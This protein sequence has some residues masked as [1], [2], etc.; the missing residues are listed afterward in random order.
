MGPYEMVITYSK[1][2][3]TL[4]RTRFGATGDG[5]IQQLRSIPDK[6]PEP[7]HSSILQLGRIRNKLVHED[8]FEL[9]DVEGYQQQ[10]ERVIQQLK[11]L[12]VHG[13]GRTVFTSQSTKTTHSRGHPAG[14]DED[15]LG[16]EAVAFTLYLTSSTLI[17]TVLMG[18]LIQDFEVLMLLPTLL[19]LGVSGIN[20]LRVQGGNILVILTV[21]GWALM[22]FLFGKSGG[23]TLGLL[24]GLLWLPV[25]QA[26][27]R[28]RNARV[29]GVL[30]SIR[31][32]AR[33]GRYLLL[34]VVVL[35]VLLGAWVSWGK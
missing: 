3:E 26:V 4:L 25:C 20:T 24:L 19:V 34:G 7:T 10:A 17:F 33:T 2:I 29:Q 35:G 27:S 15:P 9:R 11:A 13:T 5:M 30:G 14:T 6:I 18:V 22:G 31:Q 21:L 16:P 23:I 1:Q 8:G 12:P 28:S 32:L